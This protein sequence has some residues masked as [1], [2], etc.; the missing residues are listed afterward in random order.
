MKLKALC[1][2]LFAALIINPAFAGWRVGGDLI[3]EGDSVIRVI[4][5]AGAPAYK[6]TLET[7][8]G[9]AVGEIWYYQ[10]TGYNAKTI[11]ITIKHGV[12]TSIQ[13]SKR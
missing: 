5:V 13:F 1:L 2:I 7:K 10:K 11:V 4:E 3:T 6:Q 9:G 8:F 12:V